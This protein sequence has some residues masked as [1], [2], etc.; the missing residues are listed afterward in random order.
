MAVVNRPLKG[1]TL[2]SWRAARSPKAEPKMGPP[3]LA[4]APDHSAL[5][6]NDPYAFAA[7]H[8]RLA[9]L[10]R[11]SVMTNVT[12]GAVVVVLAG[13]FSSLVPL[14]E[15][16]PMFIRTD[17]A[18][19]R[20][21]RVE[22]LQQSVKGFDLVLET[23]AKRYVRLLLEIDSASQPARFNEAFAMTDRAFFDRFKKERLDSGDLDK[24]LT[25]GLVRRVQIE[26]ADRLA[27]PVLEGRGT[28]TYAV[29]FVQTDQRGGE[30]IE[31][32][33]L[34]AYLQVR[35]SP[36]EAK[37]SDLYENPLGVRVM[38]LTLKERSQKPPKT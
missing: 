30:V 14:K 24:A 29:N 11:L 7:V 23:M 12:L 25:S 18:E 8:A 37:A 3:D 34:T 15:V 16:R 27:N 32:K 5:R 1:F 36:F 33:L 13:A 6:A 35:T 10:L 38:D 2:P 22:P 21:Y 26:T 28:Y 20:V 9:W 4:P 17:S 31:R 19:D